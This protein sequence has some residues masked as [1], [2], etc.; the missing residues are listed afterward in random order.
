MVLAVPA[1]EHSHDGEAGGPKS[2]NEVFDGVVP[3]PMVVPGEEYGKRE[4]WFF[5]EHQ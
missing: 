1:K 5:M 4:P 3:V 2:L